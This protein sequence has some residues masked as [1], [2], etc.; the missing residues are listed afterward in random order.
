MNSPPAVH[1]S[2]IDVSLG[3]DSESV[4]PKELTDLTTRPA[5]PIQL[6]QVFPVDNVNVPF[7]RSAT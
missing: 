1:F 2:G 4:K 3:I 6:V 5:D 7:A